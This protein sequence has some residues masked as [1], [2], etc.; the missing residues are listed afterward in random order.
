MKI[1]WIG[2][3]AEEELGLRL[4]PSTVVEEMLNKRR[5][6]EGEEGTVGGTKGGEKV[7]EKERELSKVSK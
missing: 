3:K 5:R 1:I 6:E 4:K 7:E 2:S